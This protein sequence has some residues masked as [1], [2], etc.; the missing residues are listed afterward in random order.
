MG[1]SI[2]RCPS[3]VQSF[4]K[5]Q[6]PSLRKLS[7]HTI[8][9]F[10]SVEILYHIIRLCAVKKNIDHLKY[11]QI[12]AIITTQHATAHL[13]IKKE[14]ISFYNWIGNNVREQ[15]FI[16]SFSCHRRCHGKLG[17]DLSNTINTSEIKLFILWQ[18]TVDNEQW[19]KEEKIDNQSYCT[20]GKGLKLHF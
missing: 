15:I 17:F 5:R 12:K 16:N 2:W 1:I 8:I 13:H 7:G 9:K 11:I 14:V 19:S 10:I 18:W 6:C 4:T 20:W 3:S